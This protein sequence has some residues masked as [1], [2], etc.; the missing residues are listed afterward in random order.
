MPLYAAISFTIKPLATMQVRVKMSETITAAA[1]KSPE[2]PRV[3]HPC[4]E[5]WL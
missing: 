1:Q 2:T 4:G 5:H 3:A